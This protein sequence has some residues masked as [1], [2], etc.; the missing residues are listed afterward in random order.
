M[1]IFWPVYLT[2]AAV[3]TAV[4]WVYAPQIRESLPEEARDLMCRQADNFAKVWSRAF[5]GKP[6]VAPV[7]V[8]EQPMVAPVQDQPQPVA[9]AV[10]EAPARPVRSA[11]PVP[12]PAATVQA[13]K[14]AVAAA[15]AA[16]AGGNAPAEEEEDMPSLR[17][18]M[19][20]DPKDA[21]WGVV[22]QV[23]RIR[24]LSDG[25][26][27]GTVEGGRILVISQRQRGES[28]YE[29]IG[30]FAVHQREEP[31]IMSATDLYCFTGDFNKLSTRQQIALTTY[32]KLRGE[33]EALKAR[34]LKESGAKSPFFAQTVEANK[35]LKAL[36][37]KA[38]ELESKDRTDSQLA[39]LKNEQAV[40][41][42][43]Y[44]KLLEKHRAWKKEHASELS[45]PEKDPKYL[46]LRTQ[47]QGYAKAIPGMAY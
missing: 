10:V 16:G 43:K 15:N 40:A 19:Q 45:D 21:A 44:V 26:D 38:S 42:D 9:P 22:N 31:V 30:N 24:D 2:V 14:R 4:V 18:V 3:G 47:M 27:A 46:E 37:A 7:P 35:Q 41:H 32:Y 23:A 6:S 28:G 1:K 39:K 8:D 36:A 5:G 25:S 29:L 13:A 12:P 34:L 33:A 11:R 17:G 20:A